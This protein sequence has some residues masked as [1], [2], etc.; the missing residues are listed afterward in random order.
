MKLGLACVR[1]GVRVSRPAWARGLKHA[2]DAEKA[3][4][5]LSRPAWA[6]GLKLVLAPDAVHWI[7]SR[8]AWARGLKPH[9]SLAGV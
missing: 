7:E 9:A 4:V 2:S 8:P 5:L 1:H 3:H 6:R